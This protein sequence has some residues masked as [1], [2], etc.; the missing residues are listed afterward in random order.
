MKRIYT[1]CSFFLINAILLC[2]P[3]ILQAQIVTGTVTDSQTG[4]LLPGVNIVIQGSGN[5]GTST[6]ADG[7][8]ELNVPS[9]DES[10]IISFVGYRTKVVEINGRESLDIAITPQILE[11]D[12]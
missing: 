12:E 1:I 6:D 7:A 9:L 4:E 10:L 2:L 11:S 5:L 3:G 8:F